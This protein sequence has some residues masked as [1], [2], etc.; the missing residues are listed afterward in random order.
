MGRGGKMW[1]IFL[2]CLIYFFS[3]CTLI[4]D[5]FPSLF[6]SR[7]T[8][9]PKAKAKGKETKRNVMGHQVGGKISMPVR[10]RLFGVT[11]QMLITH[12]A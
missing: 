2:H 6:I 3:F 12:S 1:H 8:L 5:S 11:P 7:L 4:L 10:P 9:G